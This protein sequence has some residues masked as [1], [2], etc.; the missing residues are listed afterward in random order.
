MGYFFKHI[1]HLDVVRY[2]LCEYGVLCAFTF[3]SVHARSWEYMYY[4]MNTSMYVRIY[5]CY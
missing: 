4:K 2:K 1:L 5:E 3:P